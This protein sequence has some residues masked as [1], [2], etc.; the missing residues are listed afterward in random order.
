MDSQLALFETPPPA[1]PKYRLFVG[2]FPSPGAVEPISKLQADSRD[3]FGLSGRFRSRNHLHMTLHHIDDYPEIPQ[4]VIETAAEACAAAFKGQ[5]SLEITFDHVKS[6]SGRPGNLPF[7]LVNPNGNEPLMELHHRL[8]T[9]LAKRKLARRGDFKFVPHVT[10]LY[11]RQSVPEQPVPPVSWRVN[12]V[13]LVL[14]YLGETKYER[15]RCW[16]LG[17]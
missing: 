8:I 3:R 10:L 11:D 5:P 9:E 6:F 14:S 4:R 7:V 15:L 13:V 2:I 17:E 16:P 12:E 1:P